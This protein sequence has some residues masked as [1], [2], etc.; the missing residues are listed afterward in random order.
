MN[1]DDF[2][3]ANIDGEY[4]LSLVDY[5]QLVQQ[6]SE[7]EFIQN[8]KYLSRKDDETGSISTPDI[9]IEELHKIHVFNQINSSDLATY[10][11]TG[12]GNFLYYI[13]NYPAKDRIITQMQFLRC[14]HA[15]L[16]SCMGLDSPFADNRKSLYKINLKFVDGIVKLFHVL[17]YDTGFKAVFDQSFK[18]IDVYYQHKELE[19]FKNNPLDEKK[20]IFAFFNVYFRSSLLRHE[21]KLNYEELSFEEIRDYLTL[22][23]M[24]NI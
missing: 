4:T 1:F 23:R 17:T 13:S 24:V 8:I 21:L 22:Y 7:H 5:L 20:I 2:I 18:I 14:M 10:S 19:K 15:E 11:F 16:Y 12:V 3:F 9:Y 6:S